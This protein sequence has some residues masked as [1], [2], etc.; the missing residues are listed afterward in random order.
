MANIE[1]CTDWWISTKAPSRMFHPGYQTEELA[2]YLHEN[3][4]V[5]AAILAAETGVGRGQIMAFQ[6]KLGLRKIT[7]NHRRKSKS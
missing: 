7:G 1:T 4:G 6:R 3:V 2:A 5:D